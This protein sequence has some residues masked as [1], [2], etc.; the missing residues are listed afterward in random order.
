MRRPL[1]AA[2]LV[3]LAV[4]ALA[5]LLGPDRITPSPE[6]TG[7]P[8]L[9]ARL[10]ELAT[11]GHH[12]LAAFTIADGQT[13]FAGLGADEHDEFEIGSVTKTFTAGILADRGLEETTVGEIIDAAGS[14]LDDV[15][16]RELA[17]HTSGLPRLPGVPLWT[18]LTTAFTGGNPYAG[19]TRED[20]IDA[21]L[22]APLTGRGEYSYSNLG[23]ALLGHLLA[24]EAGTTYEEL[25]AEHRLT[26]LGMGDT[27]LMTE[28]SVPADAPRGLLSTGDEAEPW[29]MGGYLPAGGL[30][31]T[32]SDMARYATHLL[33]EGVPDLAWDVR[34]DGTL[35]HNGETYGFS[36]MLLVHPDTGRAVFVA[37]DTEREVVSLADTLLEELS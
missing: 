18:T 2:V 14:E 36:T 10:S 16:L 13:T 17:D 21:A 29:E 12:R 9:A 34:E 4:T 26:P 3:G 1:I 33:Q 23:V 35:G 20:V 28:G 19:I 30:R 37:G 24:A 31:S 32:P 27:Y 11:T 22:D 8:A 5:V 15:T 7:A 6:R 25:L